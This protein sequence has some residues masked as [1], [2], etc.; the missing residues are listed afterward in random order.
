MRKKRRQK[1]FALGKILR[2]VFEPVARAVRFSFPIACLFLVF[3][4][5]FAGIRKYL[6]ADDL[7]SLTVISTQTNGM[8]APDEISKIAGIRSGDNILTIDLKDIYDRLKKDRR[9]KEAVVTRTLPNQIAIDI[10][11]RREFIRL[12]VPGRAGIVV[13]D[14]E[15]YLLGAPRPDSDVVLFEDLRPEAAA[16]FS[17]ERYHDWA[18]LRAILTIRE[19]VGAEPLLRNKKISGIKIENMDRIAIVFE[20][21]FLVRVGE[22]F[23]GDLNKFQMIRSALA[24]DIADLEYIDLRFENIVAK[25]RASTKRQG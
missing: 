15:G 24:G 9:I 3:G 11:E 17:G 20:D 22:D 21:G 19:V 8:L 18:M 14:E 1:R 2:T 10:K 12:R 23:R 5:S 4:L 16:Q 7:F 6:F 13:M 25:K